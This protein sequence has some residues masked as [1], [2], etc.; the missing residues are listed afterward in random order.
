MT[1]TEP[2][3]LSRLLDPLARSLTPGA[4]RALV[5]FRVDHETQGRIAQLAEKCNEGE[6][7]PKERAEYETYIR[8]GDLI[9]ILQSKARL[10]LKARKP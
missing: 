3:P 8:A 6:L 5:N 4:A 1:S 2:N 9:S 7:T 10:L